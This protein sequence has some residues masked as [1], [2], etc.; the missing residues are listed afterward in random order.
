MT[1]LFGTAIGASALL[2]LAACSGG[3]NETAANTSDNAAENLTLGGEELNLADNAT[4][5]LDAGAADLNA[6]DLN[7]SG[8]AEG[9]NATETNSQ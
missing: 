5:S 9:G 1:R 2:A 4:G 6:A 7:L 8:E 3:A